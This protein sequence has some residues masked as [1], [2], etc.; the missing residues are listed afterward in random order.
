MFNVSSSIIVSQQTRTS[1]PSIVPYIKPVQLICNRTTIHIK[2]PNQNLYTED[3]NSKNMMEPLSPKDGVPRRR[4]EKRSK[5]TDVSSWQRNGHDDSKEGYQLS[6]THCILFCVLFSPT[7]LRI[8]H[9][10][11]SIVFIQFPW[12][13]FFSISR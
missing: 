7:A 13:V 4:D 2:M 9:C 8:S 12:I 6:R 5:N 3:E 11:S 10:V 1:K